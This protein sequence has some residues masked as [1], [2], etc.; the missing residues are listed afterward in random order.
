MNTD[1][2]PVWKFFE[3]PTNV[4]DICLELA[5]KQVD[6]TK[7]QYYWHRAAEFLETVKSQTTDQLI[8][9]DFDWMLKLRVFFE[10]DEV[11]RKIRFDL[12]K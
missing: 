7:E 4:I 5:K 1:P 3:I 8:E 6:N 10:K 2:M 11:V 9:R 12:N